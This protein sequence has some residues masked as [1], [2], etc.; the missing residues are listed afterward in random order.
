M[1]YQQ[2]EVAALAGDATKTWTNSSTSDAWVIL[3]GHAI[4]QC[5]ATVANRYLR[6][7]L[8]DADGNIVSETHAGAAATAGLTRHYTMKQ[9][10]FRESSFINGELEF[11]LAKG[12]L[13]PPGFSLQMSVEGGVAGDSVECFIAYDKKALSTV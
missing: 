2:L 6:L 12:L 3:F 5:D 11:P 4:L 10:I 7:G 1:N 8:H 9:G 13:V